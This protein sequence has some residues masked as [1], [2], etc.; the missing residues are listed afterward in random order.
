ML[1]NWLL[2]RHGN[3]VAD[4]DIRFDGEVRSSATML[5]VT[6]S[7]PQ[8]AH[9]SSRTLEQMDR[10]HIAQA[11]AAENGRVKDA[12]NRLGIPSST[13]YQKLKFYGIALSWRRGPSPSRSSD[14]EA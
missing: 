6:P 10:V 3:V 2:L 4:D 12:A 7:Q 8:P 13:L 9:D 11:L 5:A 1:R 14:G